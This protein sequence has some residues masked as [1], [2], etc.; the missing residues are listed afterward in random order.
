MSFTAVNNN[1]DITFPSTHTGIG[2]I[3]AASRGFTSALRDVVKTSILGLYL[4]F[5]SYLPEV[6]AICNTPSILFISYSLL[7]YLTLYLS[8]FNQHLQ[9]N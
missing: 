6:H 9:K 1:P 3:A 4:H 2:Q 5:I 7:Q 8:N